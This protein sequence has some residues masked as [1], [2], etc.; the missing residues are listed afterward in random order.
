MNY[1][2]CTY[3]TTHKNNNNNNN[4]NNLQLYLTVDGGQDN[5]KGDLLLPDHPP[6]GDHRVLQGMLAHDE[7]ATIEESW[8]KKAKIK[9]LTLS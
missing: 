1:G 7:L 3:D 5:D 6:E 8:R 9:I 2:K 4:N